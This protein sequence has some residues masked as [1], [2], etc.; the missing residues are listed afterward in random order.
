MLD[1]TSRHVKLDCEASECISPVPF[2]WVGRA[3]TG[4]GA[5]AEVATRPSERASRNGPYHPLYA[6]T[7]QPIIT[8]TASP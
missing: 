3:R 7:F 8:R 6:G 5:E 1:S 4:N 2:T